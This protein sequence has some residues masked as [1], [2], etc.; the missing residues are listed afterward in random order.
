M[1]CWVTAEKLGLPTSPPY[2]SLLSKVNNSN[3]SMSFVSGVNFASGGAGIFNASDKGFVSTILF[4][5][6]FLYCYFY[7]SYLGD[8]GITGITVPIKRTKSEKQNDP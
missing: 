4:F 8:Y 7:S 6:F 3:K 1:N 2:L 5:S